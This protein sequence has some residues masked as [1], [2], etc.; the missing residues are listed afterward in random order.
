MMCCYSQANEETANRWAITRFFTHCIDWGITAAW[1]ATDSGVWRQRSFTNS[2][3]IMTTSSYS[4][5]T[6]NAMQ[7][8]RLITMR[9]ILNHGQGWCSNGRIIWISR[10]LGRKWYR[11]RLHKFNCTRSLTTTDSTRCT[12][13]FC[14]VTSVSCS[15]IYSGIFWYF[16][17]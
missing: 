9:C 10:E 11:L 4:L 2:N 6:L 8:P 5:R 16:L 3:S 12:A 7:Y 14:N 1:P 17:P 13:I 15:G